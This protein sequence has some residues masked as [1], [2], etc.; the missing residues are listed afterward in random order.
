M[1]VS[2]FQEIPYDLKTANYIY[3]MCL[4]MI[5]SLQTDSLLDPFY[6]GSSSLMLLQVLGSGVRE[7]LQPLSP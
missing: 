4:Y 5:L 3:L 6:R 1:S 2:A 7:A